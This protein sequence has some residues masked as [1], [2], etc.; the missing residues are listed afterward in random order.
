MRKCLRKYFCNL[1]TK[2]NYT[3]QS[4]QMLSNTFKSK[5]LVSSSLRDVVCVRLC[6]CVRVCEQNPFLY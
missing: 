4:L 1:Y 6:V 2:M 3:C 5:H